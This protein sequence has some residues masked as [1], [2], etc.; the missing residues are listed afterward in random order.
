LFTDYVSMIAMNLKHF[1]CEVYKS[2]MK[3]STGLKW[4][5][6]ITLI[7]NSVKEMNVLKPTIL[8]NLGYYEKDHTFTNTEI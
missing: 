6:V 1:C 3:L 7:W 2:K 8:Q 5:I 4:P